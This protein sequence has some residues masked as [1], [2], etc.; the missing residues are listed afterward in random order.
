[1][2]PKGNG[3]QMITETPFLKTGRGRTYLRARR[4]L[5]SDSNRPGGINPRS[6]QSSEG[7][8]TNTS[9]RG[10]ILRVCPEPTHTRYRQDLCARSDAHPKR[11]ISC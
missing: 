3:I 2:T 8:P 5:P 11:A 1:M 7:L 9:E 10:Q 6:K 4:A